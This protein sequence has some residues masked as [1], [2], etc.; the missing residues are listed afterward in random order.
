MCV[1]IVLTKFIIIK[2]LSTVF[3]PAM[4]PIQMFVFITTPVWSA[5]LWCCT[6]FSR[7][8]F[9]LT[10]LQTLQHSYAELSCTAAL[11]C[12]HI[13]IMYNYISRCVW[14]LYVAV[15]CS[16]VDTRAHIARVRF[17]P[18]S[19][20]WLDGLEAVAVDVEV[21]IVDVDVLGVLG[22]GCGQLVA[23]V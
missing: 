4:I 5:D 3:L 14:I 8:I 16:T 12:T 13:Q 21:F 23:Q 1:C 18:R 17:R 2:S 15:H 9:C 20:S 11:L 10:I 6:C 22:V 19:D 7:H